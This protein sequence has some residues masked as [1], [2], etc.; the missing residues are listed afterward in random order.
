MASIDDPEATSQVRELVPLTDLMRHLI[1]PD[2]P[3]PLRSDY[4]Y[5]FTE[6][7]LLTDRPV[8]WL[9]DAAELPVRRRRMCTH[10][11]RA[12][13]SSKARIHVAACLVVRLAERCL[14]ELSSCHELCGSS[15]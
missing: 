12:H 14:L 8:K 4:L 1:L 7:Y 13:T 15:C 2:L 10:A 9:M 5:I 6:A 3:L 11:E